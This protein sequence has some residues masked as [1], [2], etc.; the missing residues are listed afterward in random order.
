M[1]WPERR[2]ELSARRDA[3]AGAVADGAVCTCI[4]TPCMCPCLMEWLA[5]ASHTAG[6]RCCVQT[7]SG[8]ARAKPPVAELP[9]H[10]ALCR[11]AKPQVCASG[12]QPRACPGCVPTCASFRHTA[13]SSSARGKLPPPRRGVAF[14]RAPAGCEAAAPGL[15][16]HARQ[17]PMACQGTGSGLLE[18][19]WAGSMPPKAQGRATAAAH[20][21]GRRR[22]GRRP[23]PVPLGALMLPCVGHKEGLMRAVALRKDPLDSRG[24]HTGIAGPPKSPGPLPA[25]IPSALFIVYTAR[26]RPCA[27]QPTL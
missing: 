16:Q 19:C 22:E 3:R 6:G 17:Q 5:D 20:G 21:G 12:T 13:V 24:R 1:G 9:R 26:P 8:G 18:A 10:S 2:L 27:P 15:A 25:R 11:A 14:R 4:L 7:G 23:P